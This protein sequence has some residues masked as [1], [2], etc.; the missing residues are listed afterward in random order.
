MLPL[1]DMKQ[2]VGPTV[3]PYGFTAPPGGE[4]NKTRNHV[5]NEHT[6]CCQYNFTMC[7]SENGGGD[8]EPIN[9]PEIAA[10]CKAFH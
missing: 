10:K 9:S 4:V 8:G 2:G 7:D 1:G 5:L 6:Y 3:F